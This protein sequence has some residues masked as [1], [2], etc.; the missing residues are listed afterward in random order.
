MV[1][2]TGD[3]H[4]M[5][6]CVFEFAEDNYTTT[7]DVMVILGDAGIN[8]D[9]EP[10]DTRLKQYLSG[11]PLT[12]F[13]IHGNHEKR[14]ENIAGYEEVERFGGVVSVEPQFPNLLFA[15]DG[16]IYEFDGK[17]CLVIGGA[18]SIDKHYRTAGVDWWDDE[19]PD[20]FVK[21]RVETR[22]ETEKWRVDM[23]FSHTCP[24]KF[25]PREAFL[26]GIDQQ[27][28]DNSTEKWL[29]TIEERLTYSA[30]YCGHFHI[31]KFDGRMRFMQNDIVG[32]DEY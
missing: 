5:F 12:L 11:L 32:L 1:F 29:G 27:T 19:Q 30:W 8:F 6:D 26:P 7:D 31:D 18:Y 21:A 25:M 23:V 17:R 13:C 16:E 4:G 2:I 28:V 3:T 24:Y 10:K 9:G 20:E 15:K 22:L 14:P